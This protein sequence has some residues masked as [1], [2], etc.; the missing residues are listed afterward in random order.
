MAATK[1]MLSYSNL[2]CMSNQI[3]IKQ[4]IPEPNSEGFNPDRRVVF[5]YASLTRRI[6]LA[7]SLFTYLHQ[8][9]TVRMWALVNRLQHWTDQWLVDFGILKKENRFD[10]KIKTEAYYFVLFKKK[11][12]SFS[13]TKEI[14][15][16]SKRIN[17]EQFLEN[18]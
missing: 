7:T 14:I 15:F 16:F 4:Q 3:F 17:K 12:S 13:V 2:Q 5:L 1:E 9:A 6:K 11:Y 18:K 8:T 10:C